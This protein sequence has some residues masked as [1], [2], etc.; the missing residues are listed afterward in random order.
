MEA[1][2]RGSGA[3]GGGAEKGIANVKFHPYYLV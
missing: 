2:V 3:G 1:L